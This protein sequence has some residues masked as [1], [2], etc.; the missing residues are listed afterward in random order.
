MLTKYLLDILNVTILQKRSNVRSEDRLHTEP[1]AVLMPA[2]CMPKENVAAYMEGYLIKKYPLNS[3]RT[4]FQM[5]QVQTLLETSHMSQ[6]ELLRFKTFK[7]TNCLVYPSVAFA[8]FV[9]TLETFGCIFGVV[10]HMSDFLK[11]LCKNTEKDTTLHRCGNPDCLLRIQ[12]CVKLYMTVGIHHA[13]K[14]SNIGR[15]CGQKR[16]HTML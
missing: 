13:L 11:T 10:M 6:C 1:V 16:N 7:E 12:N 3:C 9:Q 2:P 5:F 4:C 15:T 14:I 8:N